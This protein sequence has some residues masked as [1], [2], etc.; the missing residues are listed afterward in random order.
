MP[1]TTASSRRAPFAEGWRRFDESLDQRNVAVCAA[2]IGALMFASDAPSE[3]EVE[4]IYS[5]SALGLAAV[6]MLAR[7]SVGPR[8]HQLRVFVYATLASMLSAVGLGALGIVVALRTDEFS[9]GLLYALA[10]ALLLLRPPA[11]LTQAPS[12]GSD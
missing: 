8:S 7:R 12:N 6:S 4:N 2:A 3:G 5:M 1:A 10:G 9:V 11:M